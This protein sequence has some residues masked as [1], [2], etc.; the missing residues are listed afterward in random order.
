MGENK[1]TNLEQVLTLATYLDPCLTLK[2]QSQPF[3]NNVCNIAFM[4]LQYSIVMYLS[5]A[6]LML[7]RD[8]QC[9]Q[10]LQHL[11]I[12]MANDLSVL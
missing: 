8:R 7:V 9:F 6:H 10:E 3:A 2:H 1:A 11:C 4:Y 12:I 5:K